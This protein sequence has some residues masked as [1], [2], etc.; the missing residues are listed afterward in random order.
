M[1]HALVI[2]GT[3]GTGKVIAEMFRNKGFKISIIGRSAADAVH[4]V[5]KTE[6]HEKLDLASSEDIVPALQR[7]YDKNGKINYLVFCHR[8][9][10]KANEWEKEIQISLSATK[11]IIEYLSVNKHMVDLGEASVV[12]LSS[13]ASRLVIPQPLSYHIAKAGIECMTSY[14]AVSL[15]PLGIRF[16][17][18]VPGTIVKPESREYYN[19]NPD[20]KSLFEK[21]IPLGRMVTSEDIANLVEFFC[22]EKSRMVTGQK[23]V[24]DG[25]ISLIGQEG[26]LLKGL[27]KQK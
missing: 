5:R 16:N 2:G 21:N 18:I 17:A 7:I 25:G 27:E 22:D 11:T 24:V 23:I 1:K 26:L 4:E 6:H 14:Y 19:N 12:F 15:A 10:E 13:I 9:R 20:L 8:S 3:K